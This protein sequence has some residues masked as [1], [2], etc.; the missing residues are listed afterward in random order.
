MYTKLIRTLYRNKLLICNRYGYKYGNWINTDS[1]NNFKF[2]MSDK[3]RRKFVNRMRDDK[4]V[5]FIAN[6]IRYEYK[7]NKN[8][9]NIDE[10]SENI[11]YSFYVLRNLEDILEKQI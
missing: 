9:N 8:L 11:D 4:Y 3:K 10:I 2:I 6:Y 1:Y 5:N 7:N